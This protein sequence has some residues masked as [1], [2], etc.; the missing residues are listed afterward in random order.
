MKTLVVY[1]S[2]DGHTKIVVEEI[3]KAV[4]ADIYEIK[5]TQS[6]AGIMG[7]I[8]ACKDAM[9]KKATAIEPSTIEPVNYDCVIVGSPVWALTI[10]SAV[11]SWFTQ[12]GKSLK[13]TIFFVTMGGNG[14]KRAF[15]HMEALCAGKPL[16]TATF[17]DKEIAK[18]EHK[19]KLDVFIAQIKEKQ[20]S[21]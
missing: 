12:Y 16:L 8:L 21:V 19:A 11:R 9:L 15:S 10:P 4:G 6:R 13:K 1:Y 2:R 14:D 7:W 20:S 17:I 3:S 18:G 5:E